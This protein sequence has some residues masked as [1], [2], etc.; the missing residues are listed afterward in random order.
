[1]AAS[2]DAGKVS[3]PAWD[4]RTAGCARRRENVDML[5]KMTPMPVGIKQAKQEE[6]GMK[7]LLVV[8]L[9]L[10]L[11]AA[12]GATVASAADVKFSGQWYAV[13][14]YEDNRQLKDKDVSNSQAFVWTRTRVQT[15]FQIAEGLSFTTRFD[16]FERQWGSV[17]RSSNNTEDKSNSG[18]VNSVNLTLQENIEMEYG[19]V[20]F[21]TAI[22]QFDIGYQAAD[23]WG[24]VYADTPGSRPRLKYQSAFGPVIIGAIWEKVFEADTVR[25]NAT[26]G[27]NTRSGLVDADGDNYM[28]YGVYNWKGGAAGF[29]YKYY[30]Y[31]MNRPEA[32]GGFRTQLH[33][34]LPYMKATFG[35][36]YLEAE[37]VYVTGKQAK[38]DNAGSDI[39]REGYGFY[40]L[41]KYNMG[42]AYFGGQ[43]GYTS[44]DNDP[45]DTK[46]RT[47]PVSTTS[48]VPCLLFGN[49]NLRSWQYNASHHGGANGATFSTDKQNLWLW[50]G[51]GGFNPTPK[52]NV[53]GSVSYMYADKK[54]VGYDS[55]SYGWEFD[56]KASYKIYDN[57]TY[58]IGA[59]YLWTG[60]YFK[61]TN[62]ANKIGDDYLLMNQLTLNF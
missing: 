3:L 6:K 32:N 58:M 34:F 17:N 49:A 4:R 57:L 19:F 38:P 43:M 59:G 7:K 1:M 37:F 33:G 52:V 41:G 24:T 8:L 56:V 48:W 23:E 51:F 35:P 47:G 9:A 36:V 27:G 14:V 13:G 60:D 50:Q 46:E 2:G 5:F 28:L 25:L 15:V 29:L 55:N 18:K 39:D 11:I 30:D 26:T 62:T 16:A 54:P 40:L 45:N 12:F 53:E 22:G 31:R 42:P 44:G 61:G 10:G 20:T 21:A